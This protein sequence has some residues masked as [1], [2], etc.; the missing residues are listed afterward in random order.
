VTRARAVA[1][2]LAL[3]A[4]LAHGSAW[5]RAEWG[6]DPGGPEDFK[7]TVQTEGG[8]VPGTHR[9]EVTIHIQTTT[10]LEVG[11]QL[12]ALV[13]SG[14]Q[15]ALQAALDRY[16]NGSVGFGVLQYTLNLVVKKPGD[17]GQRYVIVVNR[18]FSA[19][20]VNTDQDSVS[21]PF[22]VVVFDV[23]DF[24]NGEGEVFQR[25]QITVNDDGT[26]SVN[27]YGQPGWLLNVSRQ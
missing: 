17:R 27:G 16:A 1:A 13:S 12:A 2:A 8:R 26:V 20:E 23:D 25:A 15:P 5:A 6:D 18:P 9:I 10:P 21:Y 19:Y 3:A 4:A 22:G 14:G 24:G 7:A 11:R